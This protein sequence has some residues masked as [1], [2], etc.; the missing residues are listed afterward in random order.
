M[1]PLDEAIER[2]SNLL[3]SWRNQP[4]A[5]IVLARSIVSAVEGLIIQDFLERVA[6]AANRCD[7]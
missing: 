3:R 6:R 7:E 2:A 1:T 4:G 5:E